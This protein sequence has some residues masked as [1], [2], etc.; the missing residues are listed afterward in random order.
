MATATRKSKKVE[1][2]VS[3]ADYETSL[4]LYANS[5]AAINKINADME[6]KFTKIREEKQQELTMLLAQQE[7]SFDTVQKYCEDNK[8]LMF[9]DKK[10]SVDSVF[11]VIGFRT[12][13]PSLKTLAK[14]ITWA[15]VLDNLK[16]MKLKKYIRTKEEVDKETLLAER[17]GKIA[18][19]FSQIGVKVAQD[20]TFFIDLKSEGESAE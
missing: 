13:T 10:K 4:A 11:G 16:A 12:A 17:T 18:N 19:K 14:G 15:M 1:T 5:T 20:E 3:A 2:P 9:S 8:E 6:A 7:E